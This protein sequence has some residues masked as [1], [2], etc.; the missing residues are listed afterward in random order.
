MSNDLPPN[1]A[2]QRDQSPLEARADRIRD[3]LPVLRELVGRAE[4]EGAHALAARLRRLLDECAGELARVERSLGAVERARRAHAARERAIEREARA[5]M[6]EALGM[7]GRLPLPDGRSACVICGC[8]A[9]LEELR[10]ASSP[11]AG[12]SAGCRLG[13]V[14]GPASLP[15]RR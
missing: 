14:L 11:E 12:H 3:A 15:P 9:D 7:L 6:L 8:T 1:P 10:S 4:A 13:Q 5:G 2:E